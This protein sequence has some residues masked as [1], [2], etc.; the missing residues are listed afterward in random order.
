MRTTVRTLPA[1]LQQRHLLPPTLNTKVP[2]PVRSGRKNGYNLQYS[3]VSLIMGN[4]VFTTHPPVCTVQNP[5]RILYR[6][7][8]D[9][10][11]H[12]GGI[13]GGVRIH[14][15]IRLYTAKGMGGGRLSFL[16][17]GIL[18]CFTCNCKVKAGSCRHVLGSFKPAC[19]AL[20]HVQMQRA[21]YPV[22]SGRVSI[23][24]EMSVRFWSV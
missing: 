14:T 2:S 8:L 3:R 12:G 11:Q 4:Q 6:G 21:R 20:C 10:R 19:N 7:L 9:I 17:G 18:I 16:G 13:P 1:S 5:P 24:L 22:T 23:P 15:P